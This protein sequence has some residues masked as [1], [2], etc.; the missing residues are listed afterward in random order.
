MTAFET[1]RSWV[2][3]GALALVVAGCGGGGSSGAGAPQPPAPPAPP[4]PP[5]P[6]PEPTQAEMEAASK[7]VGQATFGMPFADIV[8]VAR[9]SPEAWL[10]AQFQAPVSEHV[11]IIVR[12]GDEFG[13]SFDTPPFPGLYPRF[14]FFENAMTAR[15]P[16]RQRV[17]YALTQ[18]FVVSGRVEEIGS[19]PAGLASYYDVLLEHSFGNFRDLLRAVTLHPVMGLYLSHVNNA[20]SDPVANTFPDE[21]YARE[22]MQLFSI[23]LFELNPDGTQRLEAVAGAGADDDAVPDDT[24]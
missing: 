11:P 12:Y 21:N 5:A 13:F 17:A 2:L 22:V 8:D 20:K 10:E 15:D 1:V 4:P 3:M 14:A 7:F 9:E 23:G 19:D 24:T 18:I 6:A 16:L